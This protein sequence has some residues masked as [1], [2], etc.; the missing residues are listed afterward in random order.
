MSEQQRPELDRERRQDWVFSAIMLK[1]QT[2]LSQAAFERSLLE[3][4]RDVSPIVTK[5]DEKP[6]FALTFS[7]NNLSAY[8]AVGFGVARLW[9]ASEAAGLGSFYVE[10]AQIA[11]D[12]DLRAANY[13]GGQAPY[14]DV[15][16]VAIDLE[17]EIAAA[18]N[19]DS[20]MFNDGQE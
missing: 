4:L 18:Q 3:S 10:K 17:R 13:P 14:I 5:F 9:E 15:T 19:I 6:A 16:L 7:C 11:S 12:E 1:G 2:G 8:D 20:S